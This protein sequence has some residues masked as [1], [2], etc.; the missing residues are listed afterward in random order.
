MGAAVSSGIT[1]RTMVS[2]RG[3]V[4]S[5][6][7]DRTT[8]RE[9]QS[10]PARRFLGASA[11]TA[12]LG[13]GAVVAVLG[14]REVGDRVVGLERALEAERAEV[15]AQRATLEAERAETAELRAWARGL[16]DRCLDLETGV[17][18]AA[19][20]DAVRERAREA[21]A[22][23]V[24]ARL[25]AVEAQSSFLARGAGELAAAATRAARRG[26][27]LE[28]ALAAGRQRLEEIAPAPQ[29]LAPLLAATVRIESRTDVGSG[30]VIFSRP[31]GDGHVAYILTARH[32]VE[33]NIP[34]HVPVFAAAY[35]DGTRVHEAQG[36]VI[37]ASRRLDVALV[38]ARSPSPFPAVARLS[39]PERLQSMPLYSRVRAVGCP[40]GYAP[41]VTSGDL[42]S[43]AK[44]LDEQ[45]FW[46]VSAPTIFGN[47]GG[48]IYAAGT[49]E[50]LGVLSRISA[51]KSSFDVAVPHMGIVTS[52]VEVYD[53]L[54]RERFQFLFDD[55]VSPEEC[56]RARLAE[57]RGSPP[58][59]DGPS[60]AAPA[61]SLPA[62][63]E[64][65]PR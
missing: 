12:L 16:L 46:M 28:A 3:R 23:A 50:L 60:R 1:L 56:L 19:A 25:A 61:P 29:D 42:T 58:R 27:A 20:E 49:G 21:A 9:E 34:G 31:D 26:E 55:R 45:T 39:P 33:S 30:T 18:A 59:A 63:N 36:L 41:M 15:R 10:P 65:A 17:R 32:I 8:S 44:V 22:V 11:G 47:S 13:I 51:Y 62:A 40:L 5:S 6:T 7:A 2:A 38:E 24:D 57:T 54:A 43:K 37:A 64:R 52:L 4:L 14:Y 48:G 53:W 35:V